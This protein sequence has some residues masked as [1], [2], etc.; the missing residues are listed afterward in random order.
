MAT[1]NVSGTVYDVDG[2]TVSGA[3]VTL[4][5]VSTD[6]VVDTTTSNSAGRFTVTETIG[7]EYLLTATKSGYLDLFT[8]LDSSDGAASSKKGGLSF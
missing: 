8:K 2:N 4:K 5:S 1:A 3:T 7:G 6:A